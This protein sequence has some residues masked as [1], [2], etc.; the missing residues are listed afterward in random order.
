MITVNDATGLREYTPPFC[1]EL[2]FFQETNFLG[3][4]GIDDVNE[5]N[6]DWNVPGSIDNLNV[7]F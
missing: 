3:S 4:T 2:Y 6:M 7:L 1:E 5:E